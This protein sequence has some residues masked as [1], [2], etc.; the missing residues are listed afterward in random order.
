M[1][2]DRKEMM[3][4]R[5]H[6]SLPTFLVVFRRR[7]E[8]DQFPRRREL[9][10][11]LAREGLVLGSRLYCKNTDTLYPPEVQE[12]PRGGPP[13]QGGKQGG[14]GHQG[15]GARGGHQGQGVRGG[16]QGFRGRGG[17]QGQGGR[18]G[19][20]GPGGRREE[21]GPGG[22]RLE[23]GPRAR[24]EELDLAGPRARLYMPVDQVVADCGKAGGCG[25]S[26]ALG[27]PPDH[28]PPPYRPSLPPPRV[29]APIR[30]GGALLPSPPPQARNA[31]FQPP[32]PRP[33]A[34]VVS[35]G[36]SR[37]P[38]TKALPQAKAHNMVP[39]DYNASRPPPPIVPSPEKTP[40]E[41]RMEEKVEEAVGGT[42][43]TDLLEELREEVAEA[44]GQGKEGVAVAVA[45]SW[46]EQ[47]GELAKIHAEILSSRD[48]ATQEAT[49]VRRQLAAVYTWPGTDAVSRDKALLLTSMWIVNNAKKRE[50]RLRTDF[51]AFLD[52]NPTFKMTL[53]EVAYILE[54]NG[55]SLT[56]VGQDFD[57]TTSA[58]NF[59]AFIQELV[60]LP[61]QML[62]NL[63]DL[64]YSFFKSRLKTTCKKA[65]AA[66]APGVGK[67]L[68]KMFVKADQE[69]L[70]VKASKEKKGV[71]DKNANK[72]ALTESSIKTNETSKK[73][74][75]V[76]GAKNQTIVK[77][78]AVVKM[79]EECKS[80][81]VVKVELEERVRK[82]ELEAEQGRF[83]EAQFVE[84]LELVLEGGDVESRD[85]G[86]KAREEVVSKLKRV[87][88]ESRK[89]MEEE[90]EQASSSRSSTGSLGG[91]EVAEV[92]RAK[93]LRVRL[94]QA[95]VQPA[96][97]PHLVTTLPSHLLPI[98]SLQVGQ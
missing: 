15:H 55:M 66:K 59:K 67:D 43:P 25:S 38:G 29:G 44:L 62:A 33:Q 95:G 37:A 93:V 77:Q 88:E 54:R 70:A 16:H 51:Q 46:R 42:G 74:E 63:T 36:D 60:V 3:F 4:W 56:D 14:G 57:Q 94:F 89:P 1:V 81:K 13:R 82:L 71:T 6:S 69:K 64:L 87:M 76:K 80:L 10:E 65:E 53:E 50:Q 19:H 79:E 48:S 49:V 98:A 2:Q 23:Q 12:V 32:Q 45:E 39:F 85:L 11:L 17:H 8:R 40:L 72:Y 47:E 91:G 26:G 75:V 52:T 30:R 84:V 96:M 28:Q 24:R 18:G 61:G 9:Q 21:L 83:A 73:H 7:E 90:E 35:R 5:L 92:G 78:A 34:E 68:A 86:S 58:A 27:P 97:P 41:T 22:P 31:P 20:Q